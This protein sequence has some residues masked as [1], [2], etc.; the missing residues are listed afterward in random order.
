MLETYCINEEHI[1]VV[2]AVDTLSDMSPEELD[3]CVA[4]IRGFKREINAKE[5]AKIVL[6][7]CTKPEKDSKN[8]WKDFAEQITELKKEGNQKIMEIRSLLSKTEGGL[9]KLN[10]LMIKKFWNFRLRELDLLENKTK[11]IQAE[12][13]MV[14][15]NEL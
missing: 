1:H 6:S 14:K 13:A 2:W 15:K 4:V 7:E 12:L 11:E 9:E 10:K 5:M 8:V 3:K